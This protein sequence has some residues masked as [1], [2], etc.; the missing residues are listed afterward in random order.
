M[1]PLGRI[2]FLNICDSVTRS[3]QKGRATVYYVLG[4]LVYGNFSAVKNKLKGE[5]Y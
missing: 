5:L 3:I 2:H 1:K 4:S